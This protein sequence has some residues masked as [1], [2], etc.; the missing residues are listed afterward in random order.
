MAHK[1]LFNQVNNML[2]ETYQFYYT[3]VNNK[4]CLNSYT[5]SGFYEKTKFLFNM[6]GELFSLFYSTSYESNESIFKK[7][8]NILEDKFSD[9]HLQN[10]SN[11]SDHKIATYFVSKLDH[12]GYALSSAA[13]MNH[14][15]TIKNLQLHGY[16]VYPYL[17]TFQ[18]EIENS[19]LSHK[20]NGEK[21]D[22]LYIH[23]HGGQD[24]IDILNSKIRTLNSRDDL[25]FE[26]L[27]IKADI[28]LNSCSTGSKLYSSFA[29]KVAQDN[30]GT[31]VFGATE[32][33]FTSSINFINENDNS[34]IDDVEYH[35]SNHLYLPAFTEDTM[36]KFCFS[37]ELNQFLDIC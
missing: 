19:L 10:K 18:I 20:L 3:D 36:H 28:I 17:V 30:P 31:R 27:N 15:Y 9:I 1:I 6:V 14:F 33:L 2:E 23:A 22:L 11:T 24:G 34:L 5:W 32:I 21:I 8:K 35:L 4:S 25:S 37:S 16:K 26:N 7:T 29:A 13:M 12:N